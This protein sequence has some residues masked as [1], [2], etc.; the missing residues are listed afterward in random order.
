MFIKRKGGG[1]HDENKIDDIVNKTLQQEE[2]D[3]EKE[4]QG[5]KN[6]LRKNV[7]LSKCGYTSDCEAYNCR[8]KKMKQRFITKIEIYYKTELQKNITAG[9]HGKTGEIAFE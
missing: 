8:R 6:Y 7:N 9:Y 3:E 5:E 1:V 2:K 4:E